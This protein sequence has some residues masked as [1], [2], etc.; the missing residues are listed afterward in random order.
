MYGFEESKNTPPEIIDP[1]ALWTTV[2][3]NTE[4]MKYRMKNHP[5]Y[6]RLVVIAFHL[7]MLPCYIGGIVWDTLIYELF[8]WTFYFLSFSQLGLIQTRQI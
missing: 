7:V 5:V 1:F 4:I 3:A 2:K 8:L 6:W